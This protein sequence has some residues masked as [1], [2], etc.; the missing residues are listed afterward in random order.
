M[1]VTT[2]KALFRYFEALYNLNKNLLTLCG[3]NA[4]HH[5]DGQEDYID[6]IIITIPRLIPF[7]FRRNSDEIILINTDGLMRFSNDILCISRDYENI[8]HTH[9]DF[10]V[11]TKK[12]RN[13][14]EHE[15]D[16]ARVKS[17]CSSPAS[18]FHVTYTIDDETGEKSFTIDSEELIQMVKDLNALFSKIQKEVRTF[19]SQ[20]DKETDKYLWRLT[21]Y[22][23]INF[24]KIYESDL[25]PVFGQSM[26]PF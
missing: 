26:L 9:Y 14:L 8:F 24:N 16:N 5:A 22:D 3:T 20:I 11:K 10:L 18:V 15:I 23:F 13:K 6:E 12:I 19:A 1:N 17:S 4:Y 25:L 21:R 2:I 7:K